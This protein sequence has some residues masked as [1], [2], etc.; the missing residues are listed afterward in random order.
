MRGDEEPK[1]RS[2]SGVNAPRDSVAPWRVVSASELPGMRIRVSFVDGT[3]GEVHLAPFIRSPRVVGT[4]F[5]VFQDSTQ[6]AQVRVVNGVL[7]WPNGADLAPDAMY[8]AIRATGTWVV[9]VE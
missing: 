4:L 8:D 2:T 7:C 3:Q 5:E 9:A 6:F 1:A